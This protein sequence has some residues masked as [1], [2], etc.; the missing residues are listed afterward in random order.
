[1]NCSQFATN[2]AY[3]SQCNCTDHTLAAQQPYGA[4]CVLQ[5][6]ARNGGTNA[7]YFADNQ[8]DL[9]NALGAILADIA[10][11]TT[12]RTTPAYSPVITNVAG[13]PERL[14][15]QQREHLPR[16]VQPLAGKAVVGRPPAA[17]LRVHLLGVG[18]HHPAAGHPERPGRRLRR[19]PELEH[20][21]GPHLH[22][23]PA[24][25][26]QQRRSTRRRRSVPTSPR[27][28]ATA[29]GSSRPRS[30]PARR[31]RSTRRSPTRR[32]AS[33]RADAPTRPT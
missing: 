27:R 14:A 5:C 22:R 6:I 2:G 3:A 7:A 30:I 10:K 29:S 26:G 28:A 21:A 19:Q 4:C 15:E 17:A 33:P 23:V 20:R 8:G 16:L 9:Q 11:N 18:L 13:E 24:G 1:M 31:R 25:R 32:W 12:T